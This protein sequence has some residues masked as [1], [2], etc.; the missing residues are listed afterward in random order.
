MLSML[1]SI[2]SALHAA[3]NL[4]STV[5]RRLRGVPT[6]LAHPVPPVRA[7]VRVA[8]DDAAGGQP[9]EILPGD[10]T[11]TPDR[12]TA[13][14]GLALIE[15]LSN[16]TSDEVYLGQRA[17]STWTDDGEVLQLLDQ[18]HEELR[19]VEKR[20]TERNKDPRLNNRRCPVKVSYTLLFPD[21]AGTEKGLTGIGRMSDMLYV[22]NHAEV[23]R[24]SRSI[25]LP[26]GFHNQGDIHRGSS[27]YLRSA[28]G[29]ILR[30]D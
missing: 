4:A 20:V 11:G 22:I 25:T 18:F 15:V 27:D 26:T 2:A 30:C 17:T 8:Q 16:H 6:Q 24:R 28:Q 3:V 29:K 1:I 12:F 14:L 10:D 9:R 23:D 19:R 7:A 5:T 13:T 21:V